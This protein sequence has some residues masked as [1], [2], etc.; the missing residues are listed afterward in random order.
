MTDDAFWTERI[1]VYALEALL[2][3]VAATPKPGLVDRANNG[4]HD[5]TDY[6]TFQ[7]SAAALS[8]YFPAFAAVGRAWSGGATG[9]L[10]ALRAPGIEAEKAMFDRT[11]GVNTHKGAIFT[12]GLLCG[13]A[14]L[15]SQHAKNGIAPEVVCGYAKDMCA[16]LCTME[17][18]V[19]HTAT[20]LS[21]GERVFRKYGLTGARGE[22]E[23]GYRVL[24]REAL[25]YYRELKARELPLNTVLCGTLLKLM[26]CVT[27][28][29]VVYR[30]D[31]ATACEV[32]N[33]GRDLLT[34]FDRDPVKGLDGMTELDKEYRKRRISPGGCADLLAACYFLDCLATVP[35]GQQGKAS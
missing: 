13:A 3:E 5:D 28:T 12:L 11:G 18:S 2:V 25:P 6:F 14:G 32:R 16:G 20:D 21:H 35:H 4:A 27:D 15:A 9:L 7:W 34:V 26:A 30:H 19:S 8:S 29:N 22:A 33:H 17:L 10:E 1:G 31:L 23:G 24:T